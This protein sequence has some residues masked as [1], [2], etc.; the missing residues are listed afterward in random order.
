MSRK[1]KVI[2]LGVLLLVLVLP[3]TAHA[4]GGF[5]AGISESCWKQ[6]NCELEDILQVFVNVANFILSIV[7][8]IALLLFVVGGFFMIFSQGESSRTQKGKN[9]ITGAL[10]G[11]LIVFGAYTL[12]YGLESALKTGTFSG[13]SGAC[14]ADTAGQECGTNMICTEL[15]YTDGTPESFYQCI[16]KCEINKGTTWQCKSASI[17]EDVEYVSGSGLCPDE[18]NDICVNTYESSYSTQ[19]SGDIDWEE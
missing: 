12:I 7:G 10:V 18:E 4:Q 13:G 8:S 2:G 5:L 3:L 17:A 15:Y 9:F 1:F 6:G 11:I 19:P 14:D 16:T